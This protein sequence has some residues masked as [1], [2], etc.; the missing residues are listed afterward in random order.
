MRLK[1]AFSLSG[2]LLLLFSILGESPDE[3]I[4][5]LGFSMLADD[6]CELYDDYCVQSSGFSSHARYGSNESCNITVI[7]D[8][9]ARLWNAGWKYEVEIGY[10]DFFL[11]DDERFW[12]FC[13]DFSQN[14]MNLVQ[15]NTKIFWRSNSKNEY[16]GWR[17]CLYDSIDGYLLQDASFNTC[18]CNGADPIGNGW[19]S[20]CGNHGIVGVEEDTSWCFTDSTLCPDAFR[21]CI[22]NGDITRWFFCPDTDS[23][24][25]VPTTTD[26]D[27]VMATESPWR[28]IAIVS[29]LMSLTCCL[30][31]CTCIYRHKYK[32][33]ARF[34]IKK[35]EHE[36]TIM[37]QAQQVDL[38]TLRKSLSQARELVKNG[39]PS[40]DERSCRREGGSDND[41]TSCE[42]TLSGEP[43]ADWKKYLNDLKPWQYSEKITI[44]KE[45]FAHGS[46][47]TISIAHGSE[48]SMK[49]A[50]KKFTKKWDDMES[51]EKYDFVREIHMSI[52]LNHKNV[53]RFFG[54]VYKPS[55][56][57]VYEFC[58]HGSYIDFR[59]KEKPKFYELKLVDRV[60]ILIGACRGLVYLITQGILHCDIA[61]RNV[62][63]DE[64]LVAKISDFGRS[65]RIN[66]LAIEDNPVLPLKWTAPEVL[67]DYKFSEKSDVWAFGVTMW[68]IL[69]DKEPYDGLDPVKAC[70]KVLNDESYRLDL[71]QVQSQEL[72]K[73][74]WS[75][76]LE[77]ESRPRM[78]DIVVA[79]KSLPEL[80]FESK[81]K[82]RSLGRLSHV[83]WARM[84]DEILME[85]PG[86]ENHNTTGKKNRKLKLQAAKSV[87]VLH[88]ISRPES[89][90]HSL[91]ISS[92]KSY[93]GEKS[94][95]SDY[96]SDNSLS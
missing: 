62:L 37:S 92:Q 11:I 89:H 78:R 36:S 34:G 1:P 43:E 81:G 38:V 16:Y 35:R 60:K 73:L 63:L 53:V 23:P 22:S 21:S 56:M 96:Y 41:K 10:K 9:A 6:D 28:K 68:E 76:W 29:I 48:E 14:G 46:F 57:S 82:S 45:D 95:E 19:G 4:S 3:I 70:Q 72:K 71:S 85:A 55:L 15:T 13:N 79:L 51:E 84:R 88:R 90:D 20:Y 17:F 18:E 65:Q 40:S 67:T 44:I 93:R 2:T 54:L 74:L 26:L 61:A 87:P 86:C 24:T 25:R 80:H 94:S 32:S 69:T 12:D 31:L 30:A 5:N 47:G 91:S 33:R 83:N 8:R 7:Y 27:T 64:F 39:D 59:D 52:N 49:L 66:K 42:S 75:C 50:V 77:P 58:F